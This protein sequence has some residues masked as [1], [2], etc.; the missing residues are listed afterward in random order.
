MDLTIVR[1]EERHQNVASTTAANVPDV[2]ST[3]SNPTKAGHELIT[4]G[5]VPTVNQK[6]NTEMEEEHD[7]R[8][9]YTKN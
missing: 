1:L 9:I 3:A 8:K 2:G 5:I 6:T 7:A 4:E